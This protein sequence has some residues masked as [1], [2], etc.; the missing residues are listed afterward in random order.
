MYDRDI[1]LLSENKL[2]RTT[3]KKKKQR[4]P[5]F[6]PLVQV[7]YYSNRRLGGYL[8]VIINHRILKVILR[9]YRFL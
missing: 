7:D 8:K 2:R 6:T 9:K 3:K 5:Y 1:F 4:C